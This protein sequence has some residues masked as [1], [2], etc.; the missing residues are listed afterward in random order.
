MLNDIRLHLDSDESKQS[1]IER[2]LANQINTLQGRNI[3]AFNQ[4]VPSIGKLLNQLPFERLSVFIDK[5]KQS[6]IVDFQS[7]L[8]LYGPDV[9]SNID[10]QVSAWQ[11]NGALLDFNDPQTNNILSNS[12]QTPHTFNHRQQYADKLRNNCQQDPVDTLVILGLGKAEHIRQF[13]DD[14]API[15]SLSTQQ[16]KNLVVYEPDWEVFRCTLSLFDW[17]SFL[18]FADQ[19][20]LQIFFQVGTNMHQIFDDISELHQQLNAKRMF[21]YKHTNLPVFINIISNIQYGRWGRSVTDIHQFDKGHQHHHLHI[22]SSLDAQNWQGATIENSIFKVN[23]DLFEEYFPDIHKAFINY[24]PTC[25]E[26]VVHKTSNTINLFNRDHG[27]FYSTSKAKEEG[28]LLAQHFAQHPNLDGL[29]FGYEGDK[30]RYYMHNTFIRQADMLLRENAESQGELPEEVKALMVFGLGSGYMLEALYQTHNIQHLIIC[31]PNPDFFYASLHAIDWTPIFKHAKEADNKLYINI[32][33]ASSQ[34]FKDLMSQFLVI[35]PHVLNETFIM[36][37]YHNP[38]LHQVLCEVR[39]QLQVIFAMGE[40]FDHVAYGIAHTVNVM[41]QK[42]PAL[43]AQPSQYLSQ[44]NK[45]TPIF[46]VGNGPSLDQSIELIKAYKGESI[47]VSCGTALQALYKNGITPDFHGEVE[48][49]RANYDWASR[50]NDRAYLKKITLLSVNGIHPDTCKLYKNVLIAFKSGESSTHCLLA[51][52][53][54]N[55]FHCLDYAYPTVTNMALSFFLSMGFEQLYLV[56]VD[57]GFADQSKHHSSASGYYEDGKQIYDYQR[58]HNADLR[59]KGNRQEWVFTKTEFNISRM[60]VEQLLLETRATKGQGVECFNLSDGVF[61]EGTIPLDPESVLVTASKLQKQDTLTAMDACFMSISS[62][63]PTMLA[64]SYQQ[65]LLAQQLDNLELISRKTVDEKSDVHQLIDDLSELLKSS[66][67]Q[68]KSLFFYYFFNS[69]NYLN[70]ALSKANLQS[71]EKIAQQDCARLLDKWRVF[72][73]D[74]KRIMPQQYEIIDTAEAFGDK[75][76]R[77]LLG[78]NERAFSTIQYFC[79]KREVVELVTQ[80]VSANSQSKLEMITSTET[81]VY[82]LNHESQNK[83]LLIDIYTQTDAEIIATILSDNNV[84]N[85]TTSPKSIGLVFHDYAFLTEF[86]TQYPKVCSHIC[87]LYCSPLLEKGHNNEDLKNGLQDFLQLD[88]YCHVLCA[89]GQDLDLYSRIIIKPRYSDA[90]L[91]NAYLYNN[92]KNENQVESDLVS[93]SM[94][95]QLSFNETNKI[96]KDNSRIVPNNEYESVSVARVNATIASHISSSNWYMF[97]QYLA[98]KKYNEVPTT[99]TISIVDNLENRGRIMHRKPFD[100]E[101]IGAWQQSDVLV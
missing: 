92:S 21:F 1:Q 9:D 70:A 36:Q 76:E 33:E 5:D 22:F 91:Q 77:F 53:P 65:D 95:S 14:N 86:S 50:I 46:L 74:A 100:F 27:N 66:K 4:F 8:T 82:S 63:L 38:L 69:I 7:G 99:E 32:G 28:Q 62:D 41:Q 10:E 17:A 87:L 79:A 42:T 43:R 26:T 72:L 25:W 84:A 71:N 60:I 78:D 93:A 58:A 56:G 13:F 16:V 31:E 61:I 90:G 30:L 52:L 37:S 101:I 44:N 68:G 6:N 47:V 12:E 34:L 18:H 23:M 49:N 94:Q 97:K 57:L 19:R 83:S 64:K 98:L 29:V 88:E 40:N 96:R 59:V 89:R 45:Q 85:N 67:Q 55:S 75:R 24:K 81:L 3:K 54:K 39:Q 35:G 48:Q 73:I 2:D 80:E 51:M 15:D 20:K 11:F